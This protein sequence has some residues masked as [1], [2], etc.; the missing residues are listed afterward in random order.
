M[1]TVNTMYTSSLPRDSGAEL[2]GGLPVLR[3]KAV[4]Q[5]AR[6]PG[7]CAKLVGANSIRPANRQG[8]GVAK[9]DCYRPDDHGCQ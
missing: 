6:R 4:P 1:S 2:R 8:S 9:S 5:F 7:E 3:A